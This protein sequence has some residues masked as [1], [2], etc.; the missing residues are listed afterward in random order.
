MKR[1]FDFFYS[2][3][4][5]KPSLLI[6]ILKTRRSFWVVEKNEEKIDYV[7]KGFEKFV[8]IGF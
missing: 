2:L 8:V 6:K 5:S 3:Q 1:H 7:W 4:F